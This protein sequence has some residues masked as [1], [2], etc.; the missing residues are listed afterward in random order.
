MLHVA[1]N[2]SNWFCSANSRDG[3]VLCRFPA[4]ELGGNSR[5][6]YHVAAKVGVYQL[7]E[8]DLTGQN[9][10]RLCNE[11]L[12]DLNKGLTLYAD[13]RYTYLYC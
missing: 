12:D 3:I 7:T 11:V 13:V 1:G 8:N 10:L 6:L 9:K 4:F 2:R 5:S